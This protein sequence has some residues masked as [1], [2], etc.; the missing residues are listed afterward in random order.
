MSPKP[1]NMED[2]SLA[3]PSREDSVEDKEA[4]KKDEEV[5]SSTRRASPRVSAQK[6]MEAMKTKAKINKVAKDPSKGE[7]KVAKAMAKKTSSAKKT[8]VKDESKKR[9]ALLSS[10]EEEK[11]I[12]R[13]KK[14]LANRM[15]RVEARNKMQQ[16]SKQSPLFTKTLDDLN[17]YKHLLMSVSPSD[18]IGWLK[19]CHEEEALNELTLGYCRWA[20]FCSMGK[21]K[22]WRPAAVTLLKTHYAES[23][24]KP[25][26]VNKEKQEEIKEIITLMNLSMNVKGLLNITAGQESGCPFA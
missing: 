22:H 25:D 1:D 7:K 5:M 10:E 20:R 15:K 4:K 26:D 24:P 16:S 2:I 19:K 6:A 13:K 3:S 14:T 23:L 21:A 11:A 9:K 17:F 12:A 8:P 18:I